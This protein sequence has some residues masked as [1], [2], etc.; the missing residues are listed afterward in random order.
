MQL[1]QLVLRLLVVAVQ[2]G[3]VL[4]LLQQLSLHLQLHAALLLQ[5]ALHVWTKQDNQG[6]SQ[7]DDLTC[8]RCAREL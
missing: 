1:V 2:H 5:V 7:E 6:N 3:V 4:L 8:S